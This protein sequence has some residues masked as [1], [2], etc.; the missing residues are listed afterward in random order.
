MFPSSRWPSQLF[1][2]RPPAGFCLPHYTLPHL[3]MS[4][5]PACLWAMFRN[6]HS[7]SFEITFSFNAIIIII[8]PNS[9][10]DQCL[11]AWRGQ[12]SLCCELWSD[13]GQKPRLGRTFPSL[14]MIL[15]CSQPQLLGGRI[16]CI[17]DGGLTGTCFFLAAHG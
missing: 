12:L 2:P 13:K 4:P 7:S 6:P 9:F 15:E 8:N 11:Q 17:T 5:A 3:S 14:E 16:S 10:P 1:E